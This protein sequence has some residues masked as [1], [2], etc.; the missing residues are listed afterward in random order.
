MKR[1]A[2]A[3]SLLFAALPLLADTYAIDKNH[4]EANFKIRHL[5]SRVTGKFD[6]FAGT[7]TTD[8][9]DAAASKVEFSIK[10]ASVDTGNGDRDKH[11]KTA[12]F[13]DAEKYPEITFKSTSIKAGSKK[14]V[15]DVTGDLTMRGVTKRVTLPVEFLGFAK[16]PWGNDRAGFSLSTTLNRKDYGINW[17]K[18]LDNGGYLLSDDVDITVDIE[19]AKS[20]AEIKESTA[21]EKKGK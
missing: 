6:D 16:D 8:G 12:D 17:N 1:I 18:A 10:T 13:F 11:L 9:K 5:M 3:V 19:A 2:L 20:K 7:I 4:S 15:Y 14:N 21:G